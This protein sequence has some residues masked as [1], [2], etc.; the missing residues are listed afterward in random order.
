M[1]AN[2]INTI[3]MIGIKSPMPFS[4]TLV[5]PDN[6]GEYNINKTNKIKLNII[7]NL[8]IT[9]CSFL[10]L[11]DNILKIDNTAEKPNKTE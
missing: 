5:S 10:F 1:L 6:L 2:A 7:F 9:N 8:P 3:E 11:N 4:D